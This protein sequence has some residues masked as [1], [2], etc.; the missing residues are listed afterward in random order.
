MS[1]NNKKG[2]TD[3][4]SKL[5]LLRQNRGIKKQEVDIGKAI[6]G[7]A[8]SIDSQTLMA[9]IARNSACVNLI[10]DCS[11][12]MSGTSSRIAKELNGFATRQAAKIY[13][14]KISL[15][16]FDDAVYP[17]FGNLDAKQFVPIGPWD[18]I[19]GTNIY[20]ALISAIIPILKTDA[21]HKLHLVITDGQNGSSSHSQEEV[22]ALITR[23]INNGEHVFLLY[24]NEDG[25]DAKRYA[26]ELG[27]KL[28]NA[29]N[30]NRSGDGIKI[31]FQTIED[32]LDGLRTKGTVPEDWAKAITAHAANPI[33]IKARKIK[34]LE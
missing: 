4:T 9:E 1:E 21:N 11:G 2:S 22:Q 3:S 31:I 8:D 13:T 24:N 20:D 14:T 26:P 6:D 10:V 23:R 5:A 33:G 15:T 19:G 25:G 27:I 30:F 28:N 29:V 32:L 34:C 16:L 7:F 12:S 18:C 17:K